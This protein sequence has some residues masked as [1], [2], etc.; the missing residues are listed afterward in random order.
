MS[1][2]LARRFRIRRRAVNLQTRASNGKRTS[3]AKHGLGLLGVATVFLVQN[4]SRKERE[5]RA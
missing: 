5:R 1:S 3:V 4:E 2:L